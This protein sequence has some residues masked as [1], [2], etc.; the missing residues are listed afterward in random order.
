M[1]GLKNIRLP[2]YDYRSNGYY[3]VTIVTKQRQKL[4]EQSIERMMRDAIETTRGV[5][6][7]TM[8]IMPDHIHLIL[9]LNECSLPLGEI[10]RRMKATISHAM[11]QPLWQPNYYEHV[12]RNENA[13]NRI[14][15][16]IIRNPDREISKFEQFYHQA[17]R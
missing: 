7:D 10:I 15:E 14:R 1:R 12:I 11:R 17:S 2:T 3:F 13:L 16:Y 5:V 4:L 8:V 6:I 9:A